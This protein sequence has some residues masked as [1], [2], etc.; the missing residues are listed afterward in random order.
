MYALCR[1]YTLHL[2]C[3]MGLCS[4]YT[5]FVSCVL[6][7]DA[8]Q[9]KRPMTFDMSSVAVSLRTKTVKTL[10]ELHVIGLEYLVGAP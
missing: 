6:L 8:K 9:T 3:L 1:L 2:N 10:N 4:V 7:G 5:F